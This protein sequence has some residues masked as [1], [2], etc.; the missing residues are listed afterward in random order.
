MGKRRTTKNKTG[1]KNKD[2]INHKDAWVCFPCIKCGE[3]VKINLGLELPTSD[4]AFEHAC[5]VCSSCGYV[6]SCISDL[7][8]SLAN[9]PEEWRSCEDPHC[10]SFWRAFFRM[11]TKDVFAY[12]KQCS[13]CGRILPVPCFDKHSGASWLPLNRQAECKACKGAINANLNRLRTKEQLFEGTIG[14]R[15]GD[16]LSSTD[17]KINIKKVFDRFGGKCFKTK[18]PLNFNDRSSWHIDHIMPSK[19]FWP[20]TDEN[21][22]LLSSEQNEAKSGKWPS[23]FYTDKELVEL[24]K[25]TGANL[26]LISSKE[27]V[28]NMDIDPNKAVSRLF[29]NVRED[30]H[31]PKLVQALKKVIL[32]HQMG[33]GLTENNRKL[34]GITER[35]LYADAQGN[36]PEP[37]E[38]DAVSINDDELHYKLPPTTF[39]AM[40]VAEDIFIDGSIQV[41]LP[42]TKREDLVGDKLDLILMYAVGDLARAKTISAGKIALGIKEVSITKE[43]VAAFQSVKHLLFHYWKD[44]HAFLLKSSPRLV[45]KQSIPS[46]YL[47]RQE[48]EAAKFLLL[49]YEPLIPEDLGNIDILKVQPLGKD[50]RNRY[51][52]FVTTLES[53]KA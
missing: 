46:D 22:A 12:W 6:H 53:I 23:E 27:P 3:T 40:M 9:F 29:D 51:L 26:E 19:Y 25:L 30:S 33:F 34:L 4:E 8:E 1:F 14:R 44:P 18:V 11:A 39:N 10:Q 49:E 50:R 20:L 5:W 35:E 47:I 21:A 7:P 17:E 52:P 31:L 42:K 16:L 36:L 32:E 13:K 24:A 2:G 28:Y 48:K 37:I 15:I 45:D 38:S 41:Y 43:Q